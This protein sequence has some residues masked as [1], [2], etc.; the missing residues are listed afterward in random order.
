MRIH[1]RV[2]PQLTRKRLFEQRRPTQLM[3]II[4]DFSENYQSK[5]TEEIQSMHFGASKSQISLHTGMMY[6]KNRS[7]S[8]CTISA[9]LNHQPPPIWT[10]LTPIS[11]LRDVP[12]RRCYSSLFGLQLNFSVPTKK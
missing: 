2:E 11:G 3:L 1:K 12:R 5:L 9:Y 7:H 8:F 10:H 6:L 4:C